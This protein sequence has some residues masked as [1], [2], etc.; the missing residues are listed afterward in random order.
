MPKIRVGVIGV[1]NCFA[2][3]LQGIEY[4]RNNK[5]KRVGLI[6]E[7]IGGYSI[8]DIEFVSAFDVAE[9]K[10][11]RPLSEAI[12][13]SPNCVNWVNSVRASDVIVKEAPILDGVGVY[14]ETVFKPIKQSKTLDQLRE[15]I[16]EEIKRTDTRILINYLPVGSQKATEF[17]ASIALETCCAFINC[18]PVFVAS[19]E[20]WGRRFA[21]KGVPIIG[22]DVKSQ[23]GSTIVHR[24]L[25]KLCSDRGVVIDRTYQLNFGG[26]TDF[27]TMLE[28]ERLKSKKIS[29]T[30]AVQSQLDY[31]LS[32]ACIHIGPSDFVPFLGNRKIAY[33]RIEGRLFADVPFS[34]ELRLDVDDKANSAAI[35][36]DAIRCAQLALD[37]NIGGP[38]LEASAYFMKH[39]PVQL[40]DWE[41]KR[42]LEE[43][44]SKL[45]QK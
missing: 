16:I 10:V 13:A 17:W 32:E 3:L 34:L 26:N 27:L 36:L 23:L 25:A 14:A 19:D 7:K 11:G 35:A 42:R 18:I 37:K 38:L 39:P 21:E 1:G 22:D 45:S 44:I 5:S 12:Y 4:Y 31:R 33:I 40:D 30:E 24:V 15:E 2:G 6:H 9:N 8:E 43:W 41:A 28:R 29:K 20:N